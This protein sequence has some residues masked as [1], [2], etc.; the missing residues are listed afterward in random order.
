MCPPQPFTLELMCNK[1]QLPPINETYN[2]EAT[3][4]QLSIRIGCDDNND[5]YYNSDGNS[6]MTIKRC[7]KA[8]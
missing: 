3:H 6:S 4:E 1:Y 8:R 2:N 5:F 7:L